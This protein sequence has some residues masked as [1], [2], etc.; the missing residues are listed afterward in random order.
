MQALLLQLLAKHW[1]KLAFL[2]LFLG[3]IGTSYWYGK[4]N[5]RVEIVEKEKIVEKVVEKIVKVKDETSNQKIN[6]TTRIVE[7]PDGRKETII[8]ENSETNTES[9]ETENRDTV[10]DRT[11][12]RE[13]VSKPLPPSK[14]R[15]G[16]IA[17]TS[18]P[19]IF[20]SK[21]DKRLD[22]TGTV[23][24]RAIGPFW[25]DGM[26]NFSKKEIGLGVSFEF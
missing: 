9:R 18:I 6:R 1:K 26:Y 20:D 15:V 5:S 24:M 10:K 2:C 14:Y 8:T 21:K 11:S 12:E 19:D 22:Y 25:A 16:V 3:A 13:T 7:H 4:T 23:G 17:S